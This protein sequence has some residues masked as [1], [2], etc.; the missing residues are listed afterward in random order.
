MIDG[1]ED[2]EKKKRGKRC[3]MRNCCLKI[4]CVEK[5]LLCCRQLQQKDVNPITLRIRDK[6]LREKFV[7]MELKLVKKRWEVCSIVI[8]LAWLFIILMNLGDM[9]VIYASLLSSGDI[10]FALFSMT[11]IGRW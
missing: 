5:V 2:V 8:G 4:P 11:L 1:V 6:E 10:T 3:S 7:D 9:N